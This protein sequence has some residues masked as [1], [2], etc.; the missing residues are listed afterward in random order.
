MSK[1]KRGD[2]QSKFKRRATAHP[3][4][5]YHSSSGKPNLQ[6]AGITCFGVK[7]APGFMPAPDHC[8]S[9]KINYGEGLLVDMCICRWYCKAPCEEW[10]EFSKAIKRAANA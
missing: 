10:E 9:K 3:A 7:G 1:F 8:K 2:K 6:N 5:T 4:K